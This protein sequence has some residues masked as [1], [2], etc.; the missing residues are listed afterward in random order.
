MVARHKKYN[1]ETAAGLWDQGE[2]S[3]DLVR[4]ALCIPGLQEGPDGVNPD[5]FS[6]QH[7]VE[8]FEDAVLLLAVPC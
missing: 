1:Y 4:R 2:K 3:L 6:P 5:Q 8:V 7:S